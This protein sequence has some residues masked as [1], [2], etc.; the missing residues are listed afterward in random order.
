MANR[1]VIFDDNEERLKSVEMLLNLSPD[2]ECAGT[3]KNCNNLLEDIART[4]PHL[5]LMD[6]DMPGMN[7]IEATRL[8]RKHY[9]LLP[10]IIQTIFEE[11]E[12]IFDSLRAGANGYLLKK[13]N[14]DKFLESLREALDGGA[15][16]TGSIASKVL[17]YFSTE[18]Q[19]ANEYHLTE[20]EKFILG[21]LVKGFSYKMIAN[22]CK[23]AYNT[24]NNHI[25]NIYDKLYVNSATEAVS[26]AIKER[27]V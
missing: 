12:K 8:I 1:I 25:R 14:P 20:R 22:E 23:I 11:N 15:P 18:R 5:I 4:A 3:F 6:I 9:D 27:L 7:G 21:L 17:L 24:V 10:V 16:M 26:L 2:F 19:S 13:T